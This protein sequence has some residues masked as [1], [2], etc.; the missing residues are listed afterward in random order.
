MA[1]LGAS[2]FARPRMWH[3]QT[4]IKQQYLNMPFQYKQ[5]YLSALSSKRV[6]LG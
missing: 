5:H 2:D 1:S 3:Q 6:M 4:S